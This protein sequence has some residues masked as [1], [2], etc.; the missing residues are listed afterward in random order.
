[1]PINSTT[2][3]K[4]ILLLPEQRPVL[5]DKQEMM[6]WLAALV[7]SSDDAIIS[8]TVDGVVTSWNGGAERIF[9]YSAEEM[10]GQPIARL[11]C[12]GG[13]D[14]MARVLEKVRRGERVSP[15]ETRRRCKDGR[16]IAVSLT[17]SPIKNSEGEIIG[18]SKIARDISG[19]KQTEMA[20]R[21]NEK[22]AAVG[23]MAS[24][25]AH[26]IN[27]PLAA[28]INLLFL[29]EN[30]ELSPE[31]R[32][33]LATAQREL[34]RV[35]HVAA[36]ALGFYRDSGERVA[37]PIAALIEDAL[38]LHE[39][40]CRVCGVDVSREYASAPPMTCHA[41]DL[42]QVMVNLIGNALDAMPSGGRL[43]VR[44]RGALDRVSGQRGLR[45]TVADTGHGMSEETRRRLFEPF[46]TTKQITGS[47]LGLWI[48]TDIVHQY[49]G[50]ISV[51]SRNVPG[52]SGSVF[53]LFLPL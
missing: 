46:Y 49:K 29:L 5:G 35:V 22:L 6:Q 12:A 2:F 24:S 27:N 39:G 17:I 53:V 37:L 19:Q 44:V 15:Y 7:E 42:R 18:A 13:E 33:Y 10:V 51:R 45:V 52:R 14:D 40:R 43:W 31:G 38:A 23:R 36:Q 34:M 11:A 28:V 41:G 25:I 50:R 32:Q 48:C 26:D 16:E 9:G 4:E 20:M 30:E 21:V 3:S 8:K 47:G 1:M